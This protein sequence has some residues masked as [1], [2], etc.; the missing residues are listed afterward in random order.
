MAIRPNGVAFFAYKEG[1][2]LGHLFNADESIYDGQ[3]NG[4]GYVF[5]QA[6][7]RH[8]KYIHGLLIMMHIECEFV[9]VDSRVCV[10]NS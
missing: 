4:Q 8:A 7:R 1:K 10:F 6:K 5:Y 2:R 3:K 9:N